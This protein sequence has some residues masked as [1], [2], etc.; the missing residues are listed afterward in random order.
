[1]PKI[2]NVLWEN[3]LRNRNMPREAAMLDE[4]FYEASSDSGNMQMMKRTLGEAPSNEQGIPMSGQEKN[5]RQIGYQGR[6]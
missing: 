2:V 1:M 3:I 5:V 4:Q 6:R